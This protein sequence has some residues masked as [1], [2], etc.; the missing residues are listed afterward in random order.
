MATQGSCFGKALAKSYS[1]FYSDDA[2]NW[3]D[4]EESWEIKRTQINVLLFYKAV[5]RGTLADFAICFAAYGFLR[6]H[7]PDYYILC[8]SKSLLF[9]FAKDFLPTF[10]SFIL[11][12]ELN[13]N[14]EK[15][16]RILLIKLIR[17]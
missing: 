13:N 6:Y 11:K 10:N 8:S 14:H 15:L 12:H 16:Q 5:V 4:Y 2:K 9:C 7:S 3:T 17:F 1:V